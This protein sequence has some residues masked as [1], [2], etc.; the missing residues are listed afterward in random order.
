MLRAQRESLGNILVLT[1][2]IILVN[3][4]EQKFNK[5]SMEGQGHYI[6]E[7]TLTSEGEYEMGGERMK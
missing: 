5:F 4:K 6:G 2:L 7:R 3:G 1:Y